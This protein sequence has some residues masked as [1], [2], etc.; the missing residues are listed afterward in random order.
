MAGLAR[1]TAVAFA[2]AF[3]KYG[4]YVAYLLQALHFAPE[5]L[6]IM[7]LWRMIILVLLGALG[8]VAVVRF[9][10]KQIAFLDRNDGNEA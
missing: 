6:G 4:I 9:L 3:I 2:S 7:G 5:L 1:T 10:E 8:C